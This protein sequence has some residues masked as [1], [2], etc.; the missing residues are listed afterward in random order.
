MKGLLFHHTGMACE[1]IS[2][3]VK[4][5]QDAGDATLLAGPV[6]DPNQSGATLALYK[7]NGA[8]VELI[9]GRVV[10]S[11]LRHGHPSLYH[12]CFTSS[13]GAGSPG[14][15]WRQVTERKPAVLFKGAMVSFWV[16]HDL[17]II[18]FLEQKEKA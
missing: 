15:D 17:G 9:H 2:A 6:V 3:T 13:A 16:H 4:A 12:T 11:F 1:A 7:W 14:G 5:M 8:I 10:E 18:E